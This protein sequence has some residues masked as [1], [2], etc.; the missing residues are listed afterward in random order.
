M[1]NHNSNITINEYNTILTEY[2]NMPDNGELIEYDFDFNFNESAIEK[3][4]GLLKRKID[5]NANGQ[6]S[7]KIYDVIQN[8]SMLWIKEINDTMHEEIDYCPFCFRTIENDYKKSIIEAIDSVLSDEAKEMS[9][10]LEKLLIKK[11]E[12]DELPGFISN[13]SINH[14]R[15]LTSQFNYEVD[16]INSKIHEKLENIYD[17]VNY[18]FNKIKKLSINLLQLVTKIKE[19]IDDYNNKI[20]SKNI[21]KRNLVNYN[22]YLSWQE[23]KTDYAVYLELSDQKNKI[24]EELKVKN[25]KKKNYYLRRR[26]YL[27]NKIK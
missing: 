14:L 10:E 19:E 24:E 16:N 25:I 26:N 3:L 2:L 8:K 5:K 20:K 12:Y 21:I 7:Q 13:E 4:D 11:F 23:I 6:V 18:D 15:D 9:F 22:N 17:I 1:Q 27:L